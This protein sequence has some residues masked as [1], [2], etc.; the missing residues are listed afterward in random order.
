MTTK[1]A[2]TD[3]EWKVVA[4][5]PV[6]AGMTVLTA[7]GGGTFRETFA[8]ARSYTDARK[9]HGES[10]LLDEIVSAKPEF[11][12]HRYGSPD[13]LRTT[14]MQRLDEAVALLQAKAT[15]EE[16]ADYREFVVGLAQHVAEAHKEHGQQISPAEQTALDEIRSHLQQ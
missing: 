15:P 10:E 14:G 16:L 11:D 5:G 6:T 7:E 2:F 3:D 1:S 13:Q 12:R 9:Q 4:E 8:L